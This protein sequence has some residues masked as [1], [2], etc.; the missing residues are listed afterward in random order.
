[1]TKRELSK[2]S[3]LSRPTIDNILNDKSTLLNKDIILFVM[4]FSEFDFKDRVKRVKEF[5]EDE[6]Q[7]QSEESDSDS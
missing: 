4:S 6:K 3:G 7:I 5:M 1:M 2:Y